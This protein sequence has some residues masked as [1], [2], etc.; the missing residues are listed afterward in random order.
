MVIEAARLHVHGESSSVILLDARR[1]ELVFFDLG[2]I[3]GETS[4]Q[5][6]RFAAEKGITGDVVATGR[7]ALVEEPGS[8]PRFYPEASRFSGLVTRNLLVSPLR[9]ED[10]VIGALSILNKPGGFSARDQEILEEFAAISGEALGKSERWA[11][12]LRASTFLTRRFEG[13][14]D[15]LTSRTSNSIVPIEEILPAEAEHA[16]DSAETIEAGSEIWKNRRFLALLASA[17]VS[18]T[19]TGITMVA[20]LWL[21]YSLTRSAAA[22]G[23]IFICL[24][25]PGVFI[26]PLAGAL[27]DRIPKR[28]ML[29]IS[30]F[31]SALI[32]LGFCG[33]NWSK[34]GLLLYGLVILQGVASAFVNGPLQ[35]CLPEFFT[36]GQLPKVNSVLQSYRSLAMLIG[37][38]AGGVIL[39]IGDI[40]WAFVIDA[41]SY[42]VSGLLLFGLPITRPEAT[43]ERLSIRSLYRDILEGLIYIRSSNLHRFLMIFFVSLAGIYCLSGGLVMPYAE[44]LLAGQYG[45]SGS[46]AL[47]LLYATMGLGGFIGSF[48]IP[49]VMRRIG[50]I[51]ALVLG[52]AL[53]VVELL[54]MG[55]FPRIAVILAVL[56]FTASS[57]PLLMVPLFTLIQSHTEPTFMGRAMGALDTVTL[58][59]LSVSFGM[60]GLMA[61]LVGLQNT[62]LVAGLMM[63]LLTLLV[64]QTSNYRDLSVSHSSPEE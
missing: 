8:D 43:T 31:F 3:E 42:L 54:V 19:G 1:R 30:R 11:R 56:V 29:I 5:Q 44:Q 16:L 18:S 52:A 33:A 37:P 49:W 53:C 22:T 63:L 10:R 51:R 59:T 62:F 40:I 61:D 41:L 15:Q 25:L 21:S 57:L 64:P 26:G 20:V 2:G 6:Q 36:P 58:A 35:A 12:T 17:F 4:L 47:S 14:L 24:T 27:A 23:A 13:S 28:Y 38:A 9:F 48:F 60:G 39:G 32:V 34:S 55:T 7:T 45:I 46:T 50:A